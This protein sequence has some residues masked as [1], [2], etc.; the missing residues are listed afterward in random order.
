MNKA[1]LCPHCL[2]PVPV[3]RGFYFDAKLNMVCGSCRK[4][5]YPTDPGAEAE[6]GTVVRSRHNYRIG[7]LAALP[8]YNPPF[9]ETHM[10][11]ED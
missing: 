9:P 6:I 8:T 4:V 1:R 3:D 10:D 7:S 2:K 5:I 11:T